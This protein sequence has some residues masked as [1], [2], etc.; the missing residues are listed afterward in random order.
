MILQWCVDQ[1]VPWLG[2][3]HGYETRDESDTTLVADDADVSV[4]AAHTARFILDTFLNN[5]VSSY[6]HPVYL[7]G[8]KPGWIF[9]GPL[10]TYPIDVGQPE[11]VAPPSLLS[12]EQRTETAR[13]I[14]SLIDGI[15]NAPPD[16]A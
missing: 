5:E 7:I 1:N 14:A 16:V 12:D 6:S 9:S 8:L 15:S 13:F 3:D 11:V 4:M 2:Q 10:D